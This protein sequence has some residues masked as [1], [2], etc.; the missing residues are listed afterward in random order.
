MRIRGKV[1]S[2]VGIMGVVAALITGIGLYVV[3]EYDHQIQ[4]LDNSSKRALYGESLNRHVTAV[5]MEARGIY[6]AANTE[7]AKQFAEGIMTQLDEIDRVLG[8]WRPLIEAEKLP[9]FD[10]MAARAAEFRTFRA[11]TARLGRDIDPAQANEQGNNEANRANRKAFQAEIDTIVAADVETYKVIQA[12]IAGFEG[13]MRTLLLV[14]A[15]I[16]ILAGTAAA[17]YLGTA[18]LGR[19]IGKL[20]LAM[21][22]LSAGKFETEVPGLNRADE[23][24]EMA[25]AVQVFKDNGIKMASMT[26]EEQAA[27]LRAAARTKTMETFQGE[28]DDVVEAAMAGDFSRSITTQF[29]DD[30][31]T[32]I[33]RNFNAMVSSVRVGLADAGSVLAALADTDLTQRM[34]G[35]HQGAFLELQTDMN[36]VAD[37]LTDVVTRLRTTSRGVKV[38]TGEIL[39][40][41]N[42]LSER[43]TRQAAT[44][45]ET[46]ATMEQLATAVAEN[47]KRA[48]RGSTAAE[49]VTQ[50][51]VQSGQVM[52][53]ATAAMGRI[54]TASEKISNIIGMIDD[55]AFQTN[56]L[57]LNAS[58][59]A[60]RAGEAGK[61]FAVVAVEVRRLAQ[62]AAEASSD[63]KA[64]IEQS[65]RE[66]DGGA[67][68]VADA[69]GKL[70]SMLDAMRGNSAMMAEIARESSQQAQAI[71]EIN[72][73]VRQMDE[74]TQH[75]AALV[76][77]T[78]AA[79]EQ[80]EA[81]A[82]ELDTIV[83]VFHIAPGAQVAERSQP[84]RAAPAAKP[85]PVQTQYLSQGNAAVA[86]DWDEF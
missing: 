61:G 27:A 83:D 76:E 56:L 58:V 7:K 31:I 52:D 8:D 3:A 47:A 39:A 23:I 46:S 69:A 5:V 26:A 35:S 20:T 19:P 67:K 43:T 14:T 36:R 13:A 9:A 60:A 25:E 12:E 24:G 40:G 55:I 38:A 50:S 37:T 33:A 45:E 53:E 78:N 70:G 59:E 22:D 11:E 2:I 84:R 18:Q 10:A 17:L 21:R 4:R 49:A 85:K 63:V 28:F 66:V 72:V 65:A 62:S 15:G 77:E 57:A 48:Q 73:A 82:N 30:D 44:I 42:D 32:R 71:E 80:T 86:N 16:G 1:L 64:L 29:D 68:L 34:T 75:N 54:T 81:R 41:A 51:A 6:A 79:I 74:M